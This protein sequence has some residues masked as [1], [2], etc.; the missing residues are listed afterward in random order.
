MFACIMKAFVEISNA[1]KNT[2]GKRTG[3]EQEPGS[4]ADAE[5]ERLNAKLGLAAHGCLGRKHPPLT[6][7]V[8]LTALL[9]GALYVE[10]H[11]FAFF[12]GIALVLSLI[13]YVTIQRWIDIVGDY[14]QPDESSPI[15][16]SPDAPEGAQPS[17]FDY[18]RPVS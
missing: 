8:I 15:D 1:V 10:M 13:S 7:I 17:T 18:G 14:S 11:L 6:G 2:A 5:Q 9:I 12:V 3:A 4:P 16:A